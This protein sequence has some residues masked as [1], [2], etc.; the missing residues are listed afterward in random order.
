MNRATPRVA[1][2]VTT[3]HATDALE[4]CLRALD[5]GGGVHAVIVVDNGGD[6][7]I[8]E[9][10]T[11]VLVR[12]TTNDGF[13]AAAN[14][15]FAHARRFDADVIV[16]LNDDVYV[17]P[18]WLA[19]LTSTLLASEDF[20]AA[21]PM[22]VLDATTPVE[23]NS[24]GVAIGGDGAGVDIGFGT[25]AADASLESREIEV[26]TGGAVAFRPQFLT[27]VGGFDERY[28]LYYEDVDLAR[29]GAAAGWR[30]MCVPASVVVHGKGTS[31]S[32]LGDRLVYLRERNRLW[33]AF[34]NE[35]T[36]TIVGAVWLSMR[37]VRHAP[38]AVHARA[39]ISGVLGGV[40]RS[41]ERIVAGRRR[42][43]G[44]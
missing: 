28:F 25:T 14:T 16:L 17:E 32:V 19:P 21:Q 41:A 43:N 44:R 34:R 10:A 24:L 40:R 36:R 23:I 7:T 35:P 15:G 4:R 20:G 8:E 18:G 27:S 1:V 13:G 6:A 29:R 2:V 30:Y 37:R 5:D 3:H 12:P 11:R 31:T 22:L 9:S 33:S 39:L 26:F 42:R 38:R